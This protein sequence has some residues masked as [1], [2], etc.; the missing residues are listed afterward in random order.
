VSWKDIANTGLYRATGYKLVDP[1]E[2]KP[3][4]PPPPAPPQPQRKGRLAKHMPGYYE[5]EVKTIVRTVRSRTMTAHEKLNAL[6]VAT[7][8]VVEHGIP[9]DFVECGVWRGGSMQAVA[10]AL[11]DRGVTDRELHLFDTFEGMSEPTEED[12][13]LDGTPAAQLLAKSPR[14]AKIWAVASLEDVRE[15]MEETGYPAERIHYCAGKVEDTIPEHAPERIAL[16][17]LDT[18]WYEST[19]HELVH[20]YERV[21]PGGVLIFDDYSTWQGARKAVDEFIAATGEPLLLVPIAAGRIAVKP[22]PGAVG[23]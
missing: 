5:P 13:A 23:A 22:A 6:V 21:P 11:L 2:L 19:R 15:G 9:G 16:L 14:D 4:P 18:D 7:H 12:K 1:R 8:Y 3:P 20:L 17:R 10:L